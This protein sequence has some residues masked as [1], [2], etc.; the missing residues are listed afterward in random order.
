M[1]GIAGFFLTVWTI[2]EGL[3][4]NRESQKQVEVELGKYRTEVKQLLGN[5]R[6]HT[7]REA[8]EQAYSCLEQSRHAIRTNSWLRAIE[9][10]EDARKFVFR[11]LEFEELAKSERT[12]LRARV[13][14]LRST[15][16][17][18]EQ[19]LNTDAELRVPQNKLAL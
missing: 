8:H 6:S 17:Y 14:D 1:L 15:I 4:V 16:K 13:I 12:A 5:I 10:T 19:R 3:R 9:K 11:V 18:I 2:F 7:F